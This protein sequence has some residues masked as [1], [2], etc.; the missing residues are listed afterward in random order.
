MDRFD[1]TFVFGDLNFRLDI[2]RKHADWL[3]ARQGLWITS[4]C[5]LF[6]SSI[7]Q[8]E[9]NQALAF[10][11]LRNI[12]AK[13]QA[14]VGFHEGDINFPPTFK[15]DVFRSLKRDKSRMSKENSKGHAY[16]KRWRAHASNQS[17]SRLDE[18]NDQPPTVNTDADSGNVG[19]TEEKGANAF[20]DNEDGGS[21]ISAAVTATSTRSRPTENGDEDE[22]DVYFAQPLISRANT[23]NAR[24]TSVHKPFLRKAAMKAKDKWLALISAPKKDSSKPFYFVRKA[25]R[26]KRSSAAVSA[27]TMPQLGRSTSGTS[28]VAFEETHAASATELS[29]NNNAQASVL[30]HASSKKSGKS[31]KSTSAVSDQESTKTADVDDRK[32]V[33][34]SS[35]KQ[36]VPS[37]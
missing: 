1:Y 26:A 17:L 3:I 20:T 2:T 21:I 19:E 13:G 27:T 35:S 29:Q 16:Y 34:D 14:F 18:Q 10:D 28:R 6:S 32:G 5:S 22:D 31:T 24:I 30:R 11:Q 7:W 4:F 33:Y 23:K 36:R 25:S 8:L 37:W 9:Y 12:M 15:Y